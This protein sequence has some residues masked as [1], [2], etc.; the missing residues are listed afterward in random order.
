MSKQ[1]NVGDTVKYISPY[2]HNKGWTTTGTILEINPEHFN[3]HGRKKLGYSVIWYDGSTGW[4]AEGNLSL[5][6]A[7]TTVSGVK[8]LKAIMET[9]IRQLIER[10]NEETSLQV[11]DINLVCRT[12]IGGTHL[13]EV[14][15][16]VDF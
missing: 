9:E 6:K 1:F 11:H 12:T 3:F 16:K 2:E 15:V 7:T 10:F 4:I 14:Q 5:E 13:Y 8:A